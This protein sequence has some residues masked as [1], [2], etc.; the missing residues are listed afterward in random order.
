[1]KPSRMGAFFLA[2]GICAAVSG[3]ATTGSGI[4]YAA[5]HN[6]MASVQ[7]LVSQGYNV[8]TPG[9]FG[10][11]A[12]LQA[13]CNGNVAMVKL[14]LDHGAK[15]DAMAEGITPLTGAIMAPSIP[16][17]FRKGDYTGVVRLLVQRGANVNI[18]SSWS[19]KFTPIIYCGAYGNAEIARILINAGA[20]VNAKDNKGKSAADYAI[21]YKKLEVLG[22]LRKAG[23]AVSYTGDKAKDII[24]AMLSLD[25]EKVFSLVEEGA[26]PDSKDKSGKTLLMYSVEEK[27]PEVIEL[28]LKKGADANAKD[29][30]GWTA[31]MHAALENQTELL[32]VFEQ[33]GVKMPYSGN[34]KHDL[35]VAVL[36]GDREKAAALLGQGVDINS[37]Y[38]FKSPLLNYAIKKN[39]QDMI[40]FLIDRKANPNLANEYGISPFVSTLINGD[41]QLARQLIEY[42]ADVSAKD[43]G[44]FTA[45]MYAIL[46]GDSALV[47]DMLDRGAQVNI[48]AVVLSEGRNSNF[49]QVNYP[50]ITKMIKPE[51]LRRQMLRAQAAAETAQSFADY[52]KAIREFH[53]AAE[54]SPQTPEIYYNLAAVQEESGAY[55]EAIKSLRKYLELVP[56]ASDAQA[57]KDRIYKLEYKRDEGIR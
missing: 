36:A 37:T 22:V 49:R 51:L 5:Y 26:D 30:D 32:K 34:K 33:A 3:C 21:E 45:L 10:Q 31:M 16:L 1:M 18:V 2:A 43:S 56:A 19:N 55:D 47:K 27:W 14:L 25:R 39:D 54:I 15:I 4:Y 11:T 8:N 29:R 57:V 35:L 52:R 24:L 50:Q 28:L 42:G 46:T 44:G 9:D 48:A 7:T 41:T 12:L 38:R 17:S 6:D 20:D 53:L 13:A 40:K 23:A